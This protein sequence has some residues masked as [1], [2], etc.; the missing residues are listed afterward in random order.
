MLVKVAVAPFV[1]LLSDSEGDKGRFPVLHAATPTG[2]DKAFGDAASQMNQ[3][4]T[5]HT[6]TEIKDG[7]TRVAVSIGTH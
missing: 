1:S 6:D 5:G 3:L 7:N 4:P 2:E